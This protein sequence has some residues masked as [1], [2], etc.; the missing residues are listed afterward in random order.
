MSNVRKQYTGDFKAKV[1]LAALREGETV[2]QLA[3]R[4]GVHPTMING[5]R[6]QLEQSA[7]SV[8]DRGRKVAKE[9]ETEETI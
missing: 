2:A 4:Y 1:A 8:F 6:K 3:S 9:K 7:A 5:W